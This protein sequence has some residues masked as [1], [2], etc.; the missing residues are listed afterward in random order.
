MHSQ[1]WVSARVFPANFG[2]GS[3]TQHWPCDVVAASRR[4]WMQSVPFPVEKTVCTPM[5]TSQT[6]PN[7][8]VV[9]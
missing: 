6:R 1:H 2:T 8:A 7:C 3:V 9:P 5:K 4:R